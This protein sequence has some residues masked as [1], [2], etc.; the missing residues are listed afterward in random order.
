MKIMVN[1]KEEFIKEGM[2]LDEIVNLKS[3]NT[4]HIL[5]VYNAEL[6]KRES[7]SGVV[8]KDNDRIEFIKFVGGG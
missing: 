5:V 2:T 4:A 8:M 6:I 1:G 3:Y 7:M